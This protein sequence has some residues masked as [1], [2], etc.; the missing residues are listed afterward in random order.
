LLKKIALALGALLA[1]LVVVI[2]MQPSS[3]AIERSA[4]IEAPPEVVYRHIENLRAWEAWNP[5][6]KLDPEMKTSYAGPEAGVGASSSWDGPN[7]GKGRMTITGV[8][9]GREVEV[10][11]EFLAPMAATNR[12]LFALAPSGTGTRVTWRMEGTNGFAAK[13]IGLVMDMDQMVG[14]E[15]EKGLAS[16]KTLA[17][18]DARKPAAGFLGSGG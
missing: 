2:A 10:E 8:K 7:A 11:L 5:W 4:E 1:L 18:A 12:A 3:F 15:F 16:M 9:P 17:E 6:Q 14:S 13:A